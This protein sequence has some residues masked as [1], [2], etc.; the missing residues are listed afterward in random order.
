MATSRESQ[1]GPSSRS[2]AA[3]LR[4]QTRR[5]AAIYMTAAI[6][7]AICGLFATI[8]TYLFVCLVL[9]G[10]LCGINDSGWVPLLLALPV[11]AGLWFWHLGFDRPIEQVVRVDAGT[12]GTV[13]LRLTHLTGTSW[14]M[15]L[16]R[17]AEHM[18]ALVRLVV[19]MLLLAP[20]LVS[21]AWR[22]ANLSRTSQ[23]RDFT[24]SAPGIARLMQGGRFPIGD[25]LQ[26]F[27]EAEPQ[28]FIG[29]ITSIEGVVFLSGDDPSLTL[30]PSFHEE[31]E[32]WQREHRRSKRSADY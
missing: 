31:F 19:N 22:M 9:F 20:R 3:W 21:L 32:Q 11:M 1:S 12:R 4:E 17:P 24:N 6:F 13:V 16:D 18:P 25:L 29:E 5:D 27:P 10:I 26:E 14:L 15:F 23:S 28:H 8:L 2:V 7:M 30:A